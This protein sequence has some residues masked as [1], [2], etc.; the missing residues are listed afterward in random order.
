MKQ[1][2]TMDVSLSFPHVIAGMVNE[3]K[4]V[5]ILKLWKPQPFT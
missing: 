3:K 2:V 4:I 1:Q 5:W